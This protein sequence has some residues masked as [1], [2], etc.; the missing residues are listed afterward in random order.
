M[1]AVKKV[2]ALA[3]QVAPAI[4]EHARRQGLRAGDRLPEQALADALGV[5]RF[6]VRAALQLLGSRG[7]L[8]HQRD[9][10]FR[11]KV[12]ADTIGPAAL[13][14]PPSQLDAPYQRILDDYLAGKLAEN[15]TAV[16]MQRE[17]G[18]SRDRLLKI[19]GRMVQE[20][21]VAKRQ[22]QGWAFVQMAASVEAHRQ[23]YLFRLA[24]EPAALLDPGYQV[25]TAAFARIREQQLRMVEGGVRKMSKLEL[26]Q[27]GAAF[28]ET[29]IGCSGNSLFIDAVRRANRLRRLAEY[30]SRSDRS[31]IPEYCREHLAILDRIEAGDRAGAAELLRRHLG[32]V[33]DNRTGG[34]R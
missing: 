31:K 5:S 9:R 3:A 23:N 17:Y 8:G 30:R 32:G 20:G 15:F 27:A 34:T 7:L 25:D 28:H 33:K 16:S 24:L 14:L 22:G 18:L 26:I 19:V 12:D 1:A 13:A 21:W 2:S 11:L 6:P 29:I 4:I 10:G